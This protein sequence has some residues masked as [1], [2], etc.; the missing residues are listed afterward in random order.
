MNNSYLAGFLDGEG[1]IGIHRNAHK[2]GCSYGIDISIGNNNLTVLE[3]IQEKFG[4]KIYIRKI[5][6]G[7][8]QEYSL[9]W[10]GENAKN[11][12]LQIKDELIIKKEQAEYAINFPMGEGRGTKTA[13]KIRELQELLYSIIKF[14]NSPI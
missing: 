1:Y 3:K 6:K 9:F 13:P 8:K 5:Y 4:G 2:W 7:H 14:L 11:L 10:S 12:L